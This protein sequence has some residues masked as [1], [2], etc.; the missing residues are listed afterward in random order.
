MKERN[1]QLI[2]SVSIMIGLIVGAGFLAIPKALS[3]SGITLGAII[4]IVVC[5]IMYLMCLLTT[6]LT[7]NTKK[8]YQM[9]GMI[10]N[11]L[12]KKIGKISGIFFSFISFGAMIAY[13]IGSS[14]ILSKLL[15]INNLIAMLS[16][17]LL[18]SFF[19][20][21]GLK[22]VEKIEIYLTSTLI[23]FLIIL[24]ILS[25]SDFNF[26]NLRIFEIKEIASPL[27]IILFS[28]GGFNV[29]SQVELITKSNKKLM[30]KAAKWGNI[31]SFL[32]FSGF[33][34]IM[35]S[36]FGNNINSIATENLS[37]YNFILGLI[38]NILAFLAMT[39]S[40]I[41]SGLL[42]KDMFIDDYNL[43][44]NISSGITMLIPLIITLFI[45]PT[46]IDILSFTGAVLSSIFSIFLAITIIV[47]RRKIKKVY[48][49]AP[50]GIFTPLFLIGFFIF[51]IIILFI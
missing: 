4:M 33:A 40:Y 32:F 26:N 7:L 46:F 47:S 21:K 2:K 34:L 12:G 8:V 28:F 35:L 42:L 50:G 39:S 5:I 15:G 22:I 27:G 44:K 37:N 1:K 24:A 45:A 19:I 25:F 30:I 13:L 51:S 6:E 31:V 17:F 14:Q 10:G 29:M 48:Y 20:F 38:G 41:M 9:P 18:I 16:Y 49:K 11:Y 23:I 43:N 3:L 36:L